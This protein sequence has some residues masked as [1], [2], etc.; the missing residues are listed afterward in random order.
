MERTQV[1]S[2]DLYLEAE[3]LSA[4]DENQAQHYRNEAQIVELMEERGYGRVEAE[5]AVQYE[6]A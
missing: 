2:E 1:K 5:M 4:I 6:F 3:R